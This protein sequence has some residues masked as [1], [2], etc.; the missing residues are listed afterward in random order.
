MYYVC[1]TFLN[2]SEEEIFETDLY[3]VY[4]LIDVHAKFNNPK[5]S[6][7]KQ[8]E[9]TEERDIYIDSLVF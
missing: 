5:K 2:M 6:N 4:K 8:K 3:T 9:E 1:K 7:K